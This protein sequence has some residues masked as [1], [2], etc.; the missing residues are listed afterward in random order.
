M[1]ELFCSNHPEIIAKRKCYKCKKALCKN[2]IIRKYHHIFCSEECIKEYRKEYLL[3][4]IKNK[5]KMPIPLMIL[6]LIIIFSFALIFIIVYKF[7]DELFSFYIVTLKEKVFTQS[8]NVF[9]ISSKMEGNF[10]K[11]K[12]NVSNNGFL[13]FS[14]KNGNFFWLPISE[15]EDIYSSYK[16]KPPKLAA[17]LPSNFIK[18]NS[19]FN[20]S[21]IFLPILSLTLDGGSEKGFSE[22]IVNFLIEEKIKPTFFLTGNFIKN[23]PEIVKKIS[24]YGFEVGNHTLTHPHLTTYSK[25]FKQET[26]PDINFERL[27]NELD[28]TNK[29]FKS[30]TGKNLIHF[31]RAPYGEYNEQIIEWGWK[32]GYFHIGWSWDS[33]DW[34]DED[35][36]NFNKRIQ[37]INELKEIIASNEKELYGKILLFH[38]GSSKPK[39]LMEVLNLI[40]T[41]NIHI[42]PVST[43]IT[44][45]A[46]YNSQ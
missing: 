41:R 31:W 35:F 32:A 23:Y 10:Y 25:N 38:L 34:I 22:E 30:T 44:T 5:A 45:N 13:L 4:N 29:L 33:M 17:F 27:K 40:K 11:F 16:I 2:C 21:S 42:V 36:P 28:E 43:L 14:G 37:K 8:S 39:E 26:S 46:F 19:S 9:N 12:V 18:L 6:I 3:K 7:R 1:E 24:K 15:K 20:K